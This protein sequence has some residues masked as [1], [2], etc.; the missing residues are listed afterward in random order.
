MK[1]KNSGMIALIAAV[2]L[3]GCPG[4]LAFCWGG[5]T[6]VISFMPGADINIGG[7]SDPSAALF[8]GLGTLCVGILF[9]A[10]PVAVGFFT[11]R[12][13]PEADEA[14]ETTPPADG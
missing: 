9:I 5:L 4:L 8:S 7:S 3:C 11:L 6:A 2:L 10:I 14:T 1:N 12:K 13:K